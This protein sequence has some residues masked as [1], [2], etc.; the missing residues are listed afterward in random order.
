MT[1][2]LLNLALQLMRDIIQHPTILVWAS[3]L[4]IAIWATS[5]LF[6]YTAELIKVW[7]TP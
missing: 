1:E 4:I 2:N 7:R 5:Q 3:I 6:R